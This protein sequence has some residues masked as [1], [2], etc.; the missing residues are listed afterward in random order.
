MIFFC[1]PIVLGVVQEGD[2][3]LVR[4][5][6]F[7]E[8]QVLS[9]SRGALEVPAGAAVANLH[10]W[11]VAC[12]AAGRSRRIPGCQQKRLR[13]LRLRAETLHGLQPA[14]SCWIIGTLTETWCPRRCSGCSAQKHPPPPASKSYE[15]QQ[16]ASNASQ[17]RGSSR[18]GSGI[19]SSP[20]SWCKDR[21]SQLGHRDAESVR[22]PRQVPSRCHV[23]LLG[24]SCCSLSPALL[25]SA[26]SH[27]M[28]GELAWE[29]RTKE[30]CW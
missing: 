2:I 18:A 1:R 15:W 3:D 19:L 5:C 17:S 11:K 30:M 20:R 26:S 14:Y 7:N 22:T 8:S 29:Q 16:K 23:A 12:P 25:A 27:Q 28:G 13:L 10:F 4:I 24:D 21:E 6:C 9:V